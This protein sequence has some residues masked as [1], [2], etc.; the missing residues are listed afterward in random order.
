MKPTALFIIN[1]DPRSSPRPAEGI[2]IA[3][4]IG[5]WK[6]VDVA[7]ALCDAAVLIL[8]EC[9][10]GLVDEDNFSR[11][12]P[13]LRSFARPVYVQTNTPLLEEIGQATLPIERLTLSKLAELAAASTYVIRF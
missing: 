8:S 1:S 2:R 10:D 12:L 13:I 11:Y 9:V 6:Q 5:V 7:V 3:G 4:G